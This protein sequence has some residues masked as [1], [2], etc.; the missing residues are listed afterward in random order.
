MTPAIII[1][2][3]W[4]VFGGSHL[5]MSSTGLRQR[6]GERLG[7]RLDAAGFTLLFVAVTIITMSALIVACSLY[8]DQGRAGLALGHSG[9]LQWV[10]MGTSF[11]GSVLMLAGLINFPKSPFAALARRMR[12]ARATHPPIRRPNGLERLSRHPFF[13]G[14]T[15]VAAVHA[16]QASTLASAVYFLGFAVTSAVGLYLQD[17][18]LR[19]RWPQEYAQYEAQT[20]KVLDVAVSAGTAQPWMTWTAAIL[21]AGVLFVWLHP[22]WTYANGAGFALFILGFGTLATLAALLQPRFSR[23]RG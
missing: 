14:L 11:F 1:L 6:L 5:A 19:S 16:L 20:G 12:S 17:R 8:A 2:T 10:M 22:V 21:A 15:V 23:S 7:E 9:P 3:A 13:V 4:V 18:K